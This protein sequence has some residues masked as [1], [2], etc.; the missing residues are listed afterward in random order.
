[1]LYFLLREKQLTLRCNDK[2]NSYSLN[3]VYCNVLRNKYL[4]SRRSSNLALA[5]G[6][7]LEAKEGHN[8]EDPHKPDFV[9]PEST[10]GLKNA[11]NTGGNLRAKEEHIDL[12]G[13]HHLTHHSYNHAPKQD[14]DPPPTILMI[15]IN[16]FKR[17]KKLHES[18]ILLA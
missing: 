18:E 11:N 6:I 1:M 9:P 2:Q 14:E 3:N 4:A 17:S 5:L 10:F 7:D 8:V 15:S 12:V 16:Q 13:K